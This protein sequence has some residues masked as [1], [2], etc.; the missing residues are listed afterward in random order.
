MKH[1]L[2]V[3]LI[4][5]ALFAT[6]FILGRAFGLLTVENIRYWLVLAQNVAPVW[7]VGTVV[8]LLFLDLFVAVPTLTITLLAGFFLGFPLGAAT[9]FAGMTAAAFSGYAISR[10]WGEKLISVLIKNEGDRLDLVETFHKNGP[11]MIMLS[12]AA[13]IVPEL[14]ACMAGATRLRISQYGLFFVVGTVPYVLIAAYAGSISSTSN[15]Q[16]AIYAALFIY[17]ILWA[18]WYALRMRTKK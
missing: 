14:T 12:R 7:V 11:A 9:A 13:P 2:K 17:L 4:V 15:P 5:G 3:M 16:P 1:L 10:V 6:T 18:G 8:L